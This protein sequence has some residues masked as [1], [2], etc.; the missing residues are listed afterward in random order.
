MTSYIELKEQANELLRQADEIR[1]SER[2]DVLA[3][4]RATINEWGF[5]AA[6]IGF[7]PAKKE[8]RK[9]VAKYRSDAGQEWCGRGAIPKWMRAEINA[10]AN[11]EDFLIAA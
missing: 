1:A 6:D 9:L 2:N 7:K 5:T 3:S 4:V 8:K 11:K 10:G